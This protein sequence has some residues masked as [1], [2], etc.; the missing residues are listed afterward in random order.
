MFVSPVAGGMCDNGVCLADSAML[1]AAAAAA[2]G[3]RE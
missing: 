3:K 1:A 2:F